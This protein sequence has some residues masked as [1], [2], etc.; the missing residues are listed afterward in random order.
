MGHEAGSLSSFPVLFSVALRAERLRSQHQRRVRETSTM[1]Q[2]FPSPA[3]DA[4]ALSESVEGRDAGPDVGPSSASPPHAFTALQLALNPSASVYQGYETYIEDGLI[5]LR[6]KIRNIEKK[7]L[8]LEGYQTRLKNGDTLNPDQMDAVGRYEEVVHNLKF[9]RELQTTLCALTQ[10]LLKAQRIAMQNEQVQRAETEQ[11]RLSMMLQVQYV[12]RSLQ[13]DDVRKTFDTCERARY[14]TTQDVDKLLNL[15]SLLACKRDER[16]SLE[17]QMEQASIVYQDLLDGKDKPV[18]GST[19]KSLKEK[20]LRLVHSGLFDHIPEPK[21]DPKKDDVEQKPDASSTPSTLPAAVSL[22]SIDVVAS[23]Q[24]LNR[25]YKTERDLARPGQG[26]ETK[27][28]SPNWK[29]DFLALKEQEPP[30]SWDMEFSDPPASSKMTLPKPWKGAAGFIPKTMVTVKSAVETKQKSQRKNKGSQDSKSDREVKKPVPVEVFNSPSSLAKDPTLRR[31]QLDH[32]MD[33]I[34]GSFSFIQDS[35]LD[36]EA[37]PGNDRSRG[38]RQSPVSAPLARREQKIPA[39]ILPPSQNS[40]PLHGHQSS[41]DT[42]SPLANGVQVTNTSDLKPH[43]ED[44]PRAKQDEGFTSPPLYCREPCNKNAKQAVKQP[45]SNGDVPSTVLAQTF[46]TPPSRRSLPATST[47]SFSSLHSVFSSEVPMTRS[48]E[49]KTVESGF[50]GSMC[51]SYSAASTL[52]HSTASTQTPPELSLPQDD[53]PM[54]STYLSESDIS[55]TSQVYSSPGPNSAP[56][57]S[58]VQ[59]YYPRSTL[60]GMTHGARGLSLSSLRSP[61]A[62]RGGYEVHRVNVH[63]P[64]GGFGVQTHREPGS[65]LYTSQENGYQL[66]HKRAGGTAARRN[67]SV[68]GWSDS[69]QV[70]SPDREGT[71]IIDSGHGDSLN[72]TPSGMP[73]TGPPPHT[74]MPVYSQLRVAFSA[75]RATNLA[76]G[77]LDQP[78]A[79]D[80]L[81]SNLGGAFDPPSGH[82]SCPAAGTYVFFF[83]ILKLAI[84]VPLYINMMRNDEVVASAYAN[85]G[86]PDHETASNHA[87]LPLRVGDHIWLRLHRGAIYGSSWKYSTFSGF[88]L[89][90]D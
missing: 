80:L 10:D 16:V 8:K 33:Q 35:L 20:L 90:P 56:Q 54:E 68:A 17:A 51:L 53:L 21:K 84:S 77:T 36:G 18:A 44:G 40:T 76:P 1:V 2:L 83:H 55:A 39:D 60:R 62:S 4:T 11:R 79:F 15:A 43:T 9:A 38:L 70:S 65:V 45:L 27:V 46:T 6:H 89:Y 24:F 75:A 42:Q 3:S 29:A 22:K 69:S 57:S 37:A 48:S 5:C 31:Q 66:S 88:L 12:L 49:P 67:G 72:I 26:V 82:F 78:I 30:D 81:H 14:A 25:R 19:Y 32:L 63:A 13:R 7:K 59:H 71:Y 23:R 87:L 52:S 34:T 85:D 28:Q 73:M 58:L 86:A 41:G 74:M 64:G 61:R 50:L 47:A